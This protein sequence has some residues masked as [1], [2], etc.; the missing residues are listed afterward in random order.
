MVGESGRIGSVSALNVT[1]QGRADT[2]LIIGDFLM[3]RRVDEEKD[4]GHARE[5]ARLG[6]GGKRRDWQVQV[7]PQTDARI[8][9]T[10]RSLQSSVREPIL[11]HRRCCHHG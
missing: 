4:I 8:Q 6:Q 1:H 5:V 7:K 2:R 3:P 11:A 9:G 10:A